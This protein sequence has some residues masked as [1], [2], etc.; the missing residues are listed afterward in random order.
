MKQQNKYLISGGGTGGH[1]FPAIAIAEAIK[2]LDQ[3][4]Q[5][6]FVGAKG[7]MEMK[8]VPDA[9]YPIV[10][11]WISGFNRSITLKNLLFPIKLVHS[12]MLARKIIRNYKP[13]VVIGTGGYAS[14]PTLRVASKKG[15]PC[16]IQE[17]NSFPGITN[18][19]LAKKV[20]AICVAY[21]NMDKYFPAEKI[22]ITGNPVRL[23]LQVKKENTTEARRHFNIRENNTTILIVGGSQGAKAINNTFLSIV[24]EILA[25]NTSIIWQTGESSFDEA[26]KLEVKYGADV[27]S[28]H[29][30]INRMDYAYG[31]A[32]VV[33]S[34]AGAIAISELCIAAKATIF[35]PLPSAA[36]DHQTKNAAALAEQHA[37]VLVPE[38]NITKQLLPAINSLIQNEVERKKLAQNIN[39]FAKPNAATNIAHKA[40]SLLQK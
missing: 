36:E 18:R 1:I 39:T 6:L 20:N 8:K 7:K 40:I 19:I 2:T 28:V 21:N 22:Q 33:I 30:F 4:A 9:G 3:T 26:K 38:E 31:A 34:R 24:G 29:K 11:L 14:G 15:I 16:L 23:S 37:A 25:Q 5:F 12:L 32:D 27:L 13:N 17:Q 10:G 35:I